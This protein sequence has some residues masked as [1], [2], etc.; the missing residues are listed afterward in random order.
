M[1]LYFDFLVQSLTMVKGQYQ[2][3]GKGGFFLVAFSPLTGSWMARGPPR[4]CFGRKHNTIFADDL[5]RAVIPDQS[6][7]RTRFAM[8]LF[9]PWQCHWAGLIMLSS[10]P[11]SLALPLIIQDSSVSNMEINCSDQGGGGRV[12]LLKGARRADITHH[13]LP[14]KCRDTIPRGPVYHRVLAQFNGPLESLEGESGN[15]LLE[16]VIGVGS[17][18]AV[19]AEE[20]SARATA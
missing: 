6:S 8:S 16:E 3:H 11:S 18:M 10:S 20:E 17:G 15:G 14:H 12:D 1:S 5:L 7:R 9:L 19:E 2:Q 13:L 4:H